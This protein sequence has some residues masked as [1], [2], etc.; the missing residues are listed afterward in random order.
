M[1]RAAIPAI[2]LPALLLLSPQ[3]ALGARP[4]EHVVQKVD[5][6][7]AEELCG[8]AVTT[9][10]EVNENVLVYEGSF[11]DLSRVRVTWTN[12]DGDWLQLFAAGRASIQFEEENGILTITEWHSGVQERLRS[13]AGITAAFDRGRIG[14]AIVIDLNDPEDPEDDE[15]VSFEILFVAG[16]HPEADSDFSLFCDVVTE[17]LG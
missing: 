16:P 4:I 2:V 5:D 10:V 6:T 9:H 12:A 13:S 17:V 15:L 8:I 7:F 3:A 14:F 1:R 11:T